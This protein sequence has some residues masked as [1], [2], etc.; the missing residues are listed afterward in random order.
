MTQV[1]RACSYISDETPQLLLSLLGRLTL[2]AHSPRNERFLAQLLRIHMLRPQIPLLILDIVVADIDV[3]KFMVGILGAVFKLRYTH[4]EADQT[5]FINIGV[6]C[7]FV[8]VTVSSKS[9][10]SSVQLIS[11]CRTVSPSAWS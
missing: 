10:L 2:L 1:H 8:R 9:A 3:S 7:S 4:D 6:R 11:R 5:H